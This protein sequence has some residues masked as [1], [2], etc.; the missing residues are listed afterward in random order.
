MRSL[1]TRPVPALGRK[2]RAVLSFPQQTVKTKQSGRPQNDFTEG[3]RA[4]GKRR[5]G[6]KSQR[7]A[8]SRKDHSSYHSHFRP[9]WTW[10]PTV[11]EPVSLPNAGSPTVRP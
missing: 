3:L 1:R 2:Q 4:E 10:R 8:A 7:G 9:N 6:Q 11:A 5:D